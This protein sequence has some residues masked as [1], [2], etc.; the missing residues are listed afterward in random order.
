MEAN[1]AAEYQAFERSTRSHHHAMGRG[2]PL[3]RRYRLG[4]ALYCRQV[5]REYQAWQILQAE[6]AAG[7]YATP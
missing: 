6:R 7:W 4:Y 5:K 1:Y 2:R 3:T